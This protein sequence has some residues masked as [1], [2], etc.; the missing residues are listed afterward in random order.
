MLAGWLLVLGV[1]PDSAH[2]AE[3]LGVAGSAQ[4]LEGV[5]PLP[6]SFSEQKEPSVRRP[7]ITKSALEG[8]ALAPGWNLVSLAGEPADPDPAAVLAP[9]AGS[10]ATVW[11]YDACDDDPWK[12]YDPAAPAVSDLTRLE[13]TQGLWIAAREPVALPS[14]GTLAAT[15]VFDL[16]VGWNLIGFPAGQVRSVDSVLAP[17]KGKY[18]RLFGYDPFDLEDPWE[19]HDVAVPAWA[20]DL[21][22]VEPGRGYWILVTEAT[23]LEIANDDSPPDVE[24]TSPEDA[25]SVTGFTGVIGTVRSKIL[26]YWRLRYRLV[27]QTAWVELTRGFGPVDSTTLTTFDPTLLLN[28]L[29]ELELEAVDLL[30]RSAAT[31]H[32]VVVEGDL[33]L[34][35]FTLPLV[36]LDI[37]VLG[38]PIKVIRV[39]DSRD[40]RPG[41]FGVGWQLTL[42]DVQLR[43]NVAPGLD[44]RGTVSPGSFPTYCIEPTRPH[45]VTIAFPGGEV[46]RFQPTP[47]P[48][49]QPLV[50]QQVVDIE[51]VPL[52]GT[53][54]ELVPLD[55]PAQS[56]VVGSFPGPIELWSQDNTTVHDSA[57]YRLTTPDGRQFVIHDQD[58]L[59]TITDINGNVLS[60]SDSGVSH[61]KGL[62]IDFQ[63]DSQG[64]IERLIDPLGQETLYQYDASGDLVS[65]TDPE[66]QVTRFNY[67]A[68]HFL[69]EIILPSGEQVVAA[70]YRGDNRLERTCGID[71]ACNQVRYDF[72]TNTQVWT[73]AAGRE[74]AYAYDQRGQV[75]KMTDALDGTVQFEYDSLGQVTKVTD[76]VGAVTEFIRDSQGRLIREITPHAPGEPAAEHTTVY[77][78]QGEQLSTVTLATGARIEI[79]YDLNG[80]PTTYRDG[81]GN[82]LWSQE[83][84]AD[85]A[86]EAYENPFVR[87]TYSN[88]DALGQPQTIDDGLGGTIE[89]TYDGTGQLLTMAL[90]SGTPWT[91]TYDGLGRNTRVDYGPN[92]YLAYG[93]GA[94]DQWTS[95]DSPTIGTIRRTVDASG[96]MSTLELANGA[97]MDVERDA[98]GLPTSL[99]DRLGRPTVYKYDLAG[100][101][102]EITAPNGG[103][104]RLVYDRAGRVLERINALDHRTAMSY[105]VDGELASLT[106]A[107]D[108][109]WSWQYE[110]LSTTIVDPL[111]R[112]TRQE[113]GPDGLLRR[114][115]HP[116][117]ATREFEY[118]L[119]GLVDDAEDF[120]TA[121]TDEGQ[122]RRRFEY[123]LNGRLAAATELAG[124]LYHFDLDGTTMSIRA[125]NDETVVFGGG[126]DF[127]TVTFGDGGTTRLD[128]GVGDEV[129]RLTLPSGATVDFTYDDFGRVTGRETSAGESVSMT[130]NVN[131]ELT[132]SSSSAGTTVY[133]YDVHG[134]LTVQDPPGAEKVVYERDLLSRVTAVRA[135]E[136]NGV[137]HESLYT[138]DGVGNLV[139]LRDPSGGLTT[140]DYDQVNRLVERSLPNGVTTSFTYDDRDQL[141]EIVH[142]DAGG[143][144]LAARSYQRQG[145]GEPTRI[146]YED[147]SA[148]EIA[149]DDALRIVGETRIDPDGVAVESVGYT[150]DLAGNR[151]TRTDAAGT[152][153]A[154]FDPGFQLASISGPAGSENYDYDVDGRLVAFS[155][156]GLDA[157]LSFDPKGLVT[158]FSD[159]IGGSSVTYAHDALGRRVSAGGS[160]PQRRF[161]MAP[162]AGDGLDAPHLITDGAGNLV[163]GYVF[164]GE[165]AL[166]RFGPD[167]PVYYLTDGQGSV[168]GLAD[169]AGSQVANFDYDSFGRLLSSTG[170]PASPMGAGGDFRFHG[171]WLEETTGLYHLRAREYDPHTGLFLSRDSALPAKHLP[172]STNPYLFALANPHVY[173]DPS[174]Q[175]SIVSVNISFTIRGI[176]SA[177]RGTAL[178]MI[179]QKVREEISTAI[180]E[181]MVQSFQSVIPL[182]MGSPIGWLDDQPGYQFWLK[183]ERGVQRAVCFVFRDPAWVWFEPSFSEKDGAPLADGWG[184]PVPNNRNNPA[185]G[186]SIPGGREPDLYVKQGR[187]TGGGRGLVTAEI[188][189]SVSDFYSRYFVPTNLLYEPE[190][191]KAI[192]KHA[193]GWQGAPF[194]VLLA[195]HGGTQAEW[196]RLIQEGLTH[197]LFL[198]IVQI[199]P[200]KAVRKR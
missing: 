8:I 56:L 25:A 94:G 10:F 173:R 101:P 144:V 188:K 54:S 146:T 167:G 138:Y 27:G 179:R 65:V 175:F 57:S 28:G 108:N 29:Y 161:L 77:D 199:G 181:V 164:A 126:P 32:H 116:D 106:D 79:E 60:F 129:T 145:I 148:V 93:Y 170:N 109:T 171:E 165:Q 150:Y 59:R 67:L 195:W 154:S 96:R 66:A 90:D 61:S 70:E 30:G 133:G 42:T 74:I 197:R 100:R 189:G 16:C 103:K 84:R 196:Q 182:Y 119:S 51:Y 143:A 135:T 78:Y 166:M 55:H 39:Y 6:P 169:G 73:D 176:L 198:V 115:V 47:Q 174:G 147:G 40:K 53:L 99:E 64:R 128:L 162:A 34:G 183:F 131:D 5:P 76:A 82:L 180:G 88:F 163:A 38:V 43:E 48:S 137:T 149:Y 114:I 104:T 23:E 41:D 50:P 127:R 18:L 4:R 91:L 118:L 52:A 3:Q 192:R 89:S 19:I 122:R 98:S 24:L 87:M 1:A 9:I 83:F 49:C 26:N 69:H 124:Q 120:V 158:S 111:A 17:I 58:G 193:K 72:D 36:D 20:N 125:P 153:T 156:D 185:K 121:V 194:V 95:I 35:H 112:E 123:D 44:W 37:P 46:F 141:T 113:F 152:A 130:W 132:S 80:N 81:D 136:T 117:G 184:C 168:I 63:R 178:H 11:A 190:Q 21:T 134:N 92:D 140:F 31:S 102:I 159:S 157:S 177:V 172:E 68:D 12:R 71:S 13:T 7:P 15:T 151:L 186:V 142:R 160:G 105:A 62:S 110:L 139:S 33:K 86:L 45:I 2:G 75:T 200:G 97:R 155:R 187:P 14:Q 107:N 191:W 85:G 22:V